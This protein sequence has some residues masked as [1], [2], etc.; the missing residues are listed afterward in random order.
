[1]IHKGQKK[2]HNF[3]VLLEKSCKCL[4]I[5]QKMQ[6]IIINTHL[7]LVQCKVIILFFKIIP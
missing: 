1:M 5:S 6:Y 3:V 7:P 2:I 4:R